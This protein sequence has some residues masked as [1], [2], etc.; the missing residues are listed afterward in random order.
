[1]KIVPLHNRNNKLRPMTEIEFGTMFTLMQNKA[2]SSEGM[3]AELRQKSFIFQ[4]IESRSKNLGISADPSVLIMLA[5]ICTTP[6]TASLYVHALWHEQQRVA[7]DRPLNI[8]DFCMMF[9]DG[10]PDEDSLEDAWSAQKTD[11]G[12]NGI[13]LQSTYNQVQDHG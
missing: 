6:G 5:L 10:F 2:D 13:D 4:I 7:R 9:A 3:L 8:E 1:M 11:E 12:H